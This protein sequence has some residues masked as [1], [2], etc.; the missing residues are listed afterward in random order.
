[1]CQHSLWLSKAAEG[2]CNLN[3]NFSLFGDV[4]KA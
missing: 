3:T 4:R 1:M 2:V